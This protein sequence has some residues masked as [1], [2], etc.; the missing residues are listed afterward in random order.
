MTF[1][2]GDA[3]QLGLGPD[4]METATATRVPGLSDVVQVAVGGVHTVCLDVRGKVTTDSLRTFH[5]NKRKTIST[6]N[7]ELPYNGRTLVHPLCGCFVLSPRG[8]NPIKLP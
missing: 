4:V 5:G 8:L 2:I 3:G 1:G 6:Q 7:H